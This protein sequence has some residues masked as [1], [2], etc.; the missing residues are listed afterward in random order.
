MQYLIGAILA[1]ILMGWME[2]H[3]L[4]ISDFFGGNVKEQRQQYNN[5][6]EEIGSLKERVDEV[7][8][9]ACKEDTFNVN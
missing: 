1:L 3:E 5:V 8:K 7:S 4:S 9:C 6:M 2:R